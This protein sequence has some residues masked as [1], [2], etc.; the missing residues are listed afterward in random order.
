MKR[1]IFSIVATVL[2]IGT[3]AAQELSKKEVKGQGYFRSSLTMILMEDPEMDPDIANSVRSTYESA[4]APLK[5]NDHNIDGHRIFIPG[6]SASEADLALFEQ[7][8][9]T[10]K[11][12]IGKALGKGLLSMATKKEDGSGDVAA[13]LEEQ[14]RITREF[15]ALAYKYLIEQEIPYKVMEKWFPIVDGK[16]TMSMVEERCFNSL[17]PSQVEAISASV[18]HQ[19][20]ILKFSNELLNNTFIAVSRYRY[21]TASEFAEEMAQE[22]DALTGGL[23]LGD[24]TSSFTDL[25]SSGDRHSYVV[26]V[27]TFLFQLDW[28]DELDS[29]I[30]QNM[31][32][33]VGF[34]DLK[35]KFKYIGQEKSH[36]SVG[37]GGEENKDKSN[38]ELVA[39]ATLRA[40][41]K[42]IAKLERKYEE[43][44]VKTPLKTVEP[45]ITAEIGTYDSV[46]GKDKYE[47]L[48]QRTNE[49]TGRIEYIRKGI[50]T[51]DPK[52]IWDNDPDSDKYEPNGAT[53][54]TGKVKDVLPGYIIRRTK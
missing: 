39:E 54:F 12:S 25:T 34:K 35:F 47:I 51:V 46:E 27:R 6:E 37:K 45:E 41:D 23:G 21:M 7:I 11:E 19:G 10:P 50:I 44:H 22:A 43:F 42:A 30:A 17:T 28:N 3:T 24:L 53:V 48:E 5:F 20:Q 16:H 13:Y 33:P 4:K 15:G 2:L 9:P 52:Q 49:K 18:D 36:A 40:F 14:K 8:N 26:A 38:D 29:A 32:N 31:E 1:V